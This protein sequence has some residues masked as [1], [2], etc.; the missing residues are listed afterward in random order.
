M[1][2]ASQYA[3]LNHF[4]HNQNRRNCQIYPSTTTVEGI[5]NHAG[6]LFAF[7]KSVDVEKGIFHSQ[8]CVSIGPR[9]GVKVYGESWDV[10]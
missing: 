9:G 3:A 2:N 1:F 10:Y 4:S 7:V 6:R 5:E 8:A